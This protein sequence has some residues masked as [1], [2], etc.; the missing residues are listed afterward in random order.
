VPPHHGEFSLLL[1]VRVATWTPPAI[2]HPRR[3]RLEGVRQTRTSIV[4][5]TSKEDSYVPTGIQENP[6]EPDDDSRLEIAPATW[7][8]TLARHLLADGYD[9]VLDSTRARRRCGIRRQPCVLDLFSCFATSGRLNHPRCTT[10]RSRRSCC[11]PHSQPDQFG[12]LH[13]RDGE[14]IATGTVAMPD[15][16]RTCS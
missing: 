9:L 11:A 7:H 4:L 8:A 13:R 10:R 16:C 15:Y 6:H 2:A 5:S 14:F 1:K 3:E 12:R